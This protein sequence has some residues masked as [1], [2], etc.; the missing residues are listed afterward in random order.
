MRAEPILELACVVFDISV[1]M[2]ALVDGERVFIRNC[3]GDTAMARLASSTSLA[4]VEPRNPGRLQVGIAASKRQC[5]DAS[6]RQLLAVPADSMGV[7]L[8]MVPGGTAMVMSGKLGALGKVRR[9]R[10]TNQF[11]CYACV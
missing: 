7:V 3:F 9:W 6:R 8:I 11:C 4:V 2:V 10:N 5:C 1:A